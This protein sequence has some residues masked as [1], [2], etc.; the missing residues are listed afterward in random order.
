ML[1]AYQVVYFQLF[2]SYGSV[3]HDFYKLDYKIQIW[4][5]EE[6]LRRLDL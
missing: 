4:G 2:W 1:K 5:I 3:P 6:R